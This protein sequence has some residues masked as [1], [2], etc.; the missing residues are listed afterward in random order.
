MNPLTPFGKLYGRVMS[1]RNLLYDRDVL[2]SYELGSRT[3]SVGNLTTGGTGKTP[4]V[5]LIAKL[6]IDEAETVCI[7]TRGY[8]RKDPRSR[9]LVSDGNSVLLDADTGGDEPTELAHQLDG[10]A[11]IIADPDR[12][13]AAKCAHEKFAITTFIL[14]DGFQHRRARRDIDIVCIDATNPCDNG[15]VLPAG[16][17][18]ESFDSLKR[19][20]AIV[21]TRTEQVENTADLE[22]RLRKRNSSAPIFRARTELRG[23]VPLKDFHAKTPSPQSIERSLFAFSGIGN[24]DNFFTSLKLADLE[25]TSTESFPD[26]HRFTQTDVTALESE[27]RSVAA[28]ALVTTAKDAVKLKGLKFEIPCYVAIAETVLDDI[29]AFEGLILS[30]RL[31]AVCPP[32]PTD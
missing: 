25:V 21:I 5:A 15:R 2:K 23:F 12:V 18:R 29:D 4:L 32:K 26:H 22:Q 31:T 19:A 20:D 27:V 30:S 1:L 28:T 14:D 11:I 3:I 9:V 13:A 17:L 24:P 8:G 7:L 10:K 6:L 16:T